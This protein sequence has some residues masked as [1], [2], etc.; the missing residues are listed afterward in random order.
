MRT[1]PRAHHSTASPRGRG[2]SIIS[3]Y[4]LGYYDVP[5]RIKTEDLAKRLGIRGSTL[6]MHRIK[7][8]RRLLDEILNESPGVRIRSARIYEPS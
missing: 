2:G 8:E 7:A 4:E 1:S 6:A 5:R 3:A